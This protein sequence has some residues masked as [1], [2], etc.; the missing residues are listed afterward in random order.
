MKLERE[1]NPIR[2]I[3]SIYQVYYISFQQGM[4]RSWFGFKKIFVAASL[5]I[6]WK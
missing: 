4:D 1:G 5:R 2:D 6:D 3:P